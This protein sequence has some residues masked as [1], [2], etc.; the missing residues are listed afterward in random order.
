MF[1]DRPDQIERTQRAVDRFYHQYG[2]CCAGCDHWRWLNSS[3]G[4]CTR[5]APVSGEE[6]MKMLGMRSLSQPAEP[7]HIVTRRDHVC[8][9][10]VDTYDWEDG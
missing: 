4:E 3:V 6:R 2:K 10:F 1:L 8:G 9:E 5:T 7:G